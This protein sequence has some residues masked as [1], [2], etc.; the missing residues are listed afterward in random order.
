MHP[1]YFTTTQ[2]V[3]H[4]TTME[5]H[6]VLAN[7]TTSAPQRSGSDAN[8]GR[9]AHSAFLGPVKVLAKKS[10][11]KGPTPPIPPPIPNYPRTSVGQRATPSPTSIPSCSN[12]W[13]RLGRSLS[14]HHTPTSSGLGADCRR[15]SIEMQLSL[16]RFW[17]DHSRGFNYYLVR[18]AEA[19]GRYRR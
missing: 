18:A 2:C 8:N 16:P 14:K 5:E 17:V 11:L 13:Q 6:G 3:V 9:G 7:P 10:R 15:P 4:S 19:I 12:P 1:P